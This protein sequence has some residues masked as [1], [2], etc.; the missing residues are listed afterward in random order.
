MDI[1]IL[2]QSFAG[3]LAPILVKGAEHLSGTV[4]D[5]AWGT[6]KTFLSTRGEEAITEQFVAQPDIARSEFESSLQNLLESNPDLATL[7][8][9][10]LKEY[11]T[12]PKI[13]TGDINIGTINS[14]NTVVTKTV[15]DGIHFG[16]KK[17]TDY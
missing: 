5:N 3:V 9:D 15:S 4:L 2:A 17:K 12:L 6:V 13:D 1:A 11:K 10:T 16:S 7:L 14:T 8:S